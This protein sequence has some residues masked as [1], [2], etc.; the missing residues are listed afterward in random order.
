M[1]WPRAWTVPSKPTHK[2]S[3]YKHGLI[4][5]QTQFVHPG[6]AKG[7]ANITYLCLHMLLVYRGETLDLCSAEDSLAHYRD[8]YLQASPRAT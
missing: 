1:G 7:H 5:I 2:H 3:T 6:C 8:G 4:H